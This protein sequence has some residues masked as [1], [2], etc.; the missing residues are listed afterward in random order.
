MGSP[1][2][3]L[4][5]LFPY[6]LGILIGS[7]MGPV[8]GPSLKIPQVS[9][10]FWMSRDP[11]RIHVGYTEI[12]K[13][14]DDAGNLTMKLRETPLRW[15]VGKSIYKEYVRNGDSIPYHSWEWYICLHEWL[16]FI[17]NVCR[18]MYLTWMVW[19]W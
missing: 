11:I 18:Q 3:K 16:M 10:G 8:W 7:G 4:P 12:Q 2:G 17:V 1:Y 9:G 15:P 5:I 19:E 14:S 6:L 13:E